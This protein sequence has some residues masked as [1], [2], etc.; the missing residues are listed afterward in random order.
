VVEK[1]LGCN[2]PEVNQREQAP[3]L[4]GAVLVLSINGSPLMPCT[5]TKARHLLER[6]KAHVVKL[7][8]FV[9]QLNFECENKTQEVSLGIDSGYKNMGYSTTTEFK[10]IYAG[11]LTL[12]DKTSKRLIEKK[13]YRRLRRSRLKYRKPKFNN[14]KKPEGWLPPSIH[15]RFDTH[16]NLISTLKKYLPIKKVTIEIAKF[17]IQKIENPDISGIGYQQGNLYNFY[18]IR[19]FLLEREH[20]KCQFCGKKFT[21]EDRPHVHHKKQRHETGSNRP[22][23][24]ALVHESC[25]KNIHKDK[26]FDKLKP[27]KSYKPETFMSIVGNKFKDILNCYVIYGYETS[28]KRKEIGLE[29]SHV[30]DAFV[31]AG[32]K[33][34]ERCFHN[35]I[36]QKRINNRTLQTNRKGFSPSIRR[37]RHEIQ[38][39]DFV[40]IK[41]KKYL[42]GG[43]SS[44]G[45]AVYYFYSDEKKIIGI[46]KINKVFHTNGLVW[47]N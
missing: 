24:L 42:C 45:A 3:G 36:E 46:K 40:W 43:I 4:K 28:I 16:I 39:R 22:S 5:V 8:P 7:N 6:K 20:G 23:N 18:N 33:N 26:L 31:I 19:A 35:K 14:R 11:E 17:D 9:I 32:G 47:I 25:H 34:Q 15:R 13:M 30:N 41:G 2:N 12:E 44:K 27:P 10:E 38:N 29:K 21:G 37:K 1:V